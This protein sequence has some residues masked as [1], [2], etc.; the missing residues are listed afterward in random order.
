MA[1]D[2]CYKALLEA[3]VAVY[4]ELGVDFHSIDKVDGWF[5]NYEMEESRQE[6]I[7]ESVMKKYKLT[8]LEKRAV[9]NSY[10]IGCSPKFKKI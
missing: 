10:Y 3:Y 9:S 4:T 5:M 8:K 2:R 7:L 1:R 6:E